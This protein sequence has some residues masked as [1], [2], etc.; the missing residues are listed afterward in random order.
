MECIVN[1]IIQWGFLWKFLPVRKECVEKRNADSVRPG[2][3]KY[4]DPLA[5]G[6]RIFIYKRLPSLLSKPSSFINIP[7]SAASVAN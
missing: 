6:E 7:E 4:F 1:I 2:A 5:L 3:I